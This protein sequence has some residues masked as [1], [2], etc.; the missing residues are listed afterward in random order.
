MARFYK[1]GANAPIY[2]KKDKNNS[3]RVVVPRPRLFY[4]AILSTVSAWLVKRY[5]ISAAQSNGSTD[6]FRYH[7]RVFVTI[8]M[9]PNVACYQYVW[10]KRSWRL[11][12]GVLC[13]F[14]KLGHIYTEKTDSTLQSYPISDLFHKGLVGIYSYLVPM[15]GFVNGFVNIK[16][17]GNGLK[18]GIKALV[19]WAWFLAW[20]FCTL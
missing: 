20:V 16:A 11:D 4:S 8:V 14:G 7:T 19:Q 5:W 18:F 10:C 13:Y 2:N 15:H 3:R 12:I 1:K 6:S 17:I 9:L